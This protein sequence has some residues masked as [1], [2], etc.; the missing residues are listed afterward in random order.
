MKRNGC[1]LLLNIYLILSADIAFGNG[2]RTL[3]QIFRE[4]ST[5]KKENDELITKNKELQDKIEKEAKHTP[6]PTDRSPLA[7][8]SHEL[9]ALKSENENLAKQI[10]DLE[11]KCIQIAAW[12]EHERK[13]K[14]AK[15]K[16]KDLK[17]CLQEEP[18]AGLAVADW[19]N[20]INIGTPID[21]QVEYIRP[22]DECFVF[23]SFDNLSA[24]VEPY[25]F[26]SN[27]RSSLGSHQN[28]KLILGTVGV[29][30]CASYAMTDELSLNGMAGYFHSTLKWYE[31]KSHINGIYFGPGA[32]YRFED[33]IVAS[34]LF[35]IKNVHKSWDLDFRVE[36][37]FD[38][39]IPD[40]WV[41]HPLIRMDYLKVW[42]N[43]VS[44]SFLY[45]KL[46]TGAERKILCREE[47]YITANF[48]LSWIHMAPLTASSLKCEKADQSISLK[49]DSKNQ[50]GVG[51]EIIAMNV[52]GMLTAVQYEGAFGSSAPMQTGRI[53][54][55]WCW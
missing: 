33:G 22:H 23:H 4:N 12:Q 41:L 52:S 46:G 17:D 10:A 45:S 53:R 42:G 32:S 11:G 50:M 30:G 44:S 19:L 35:W 47:N 36:S 6:T 3:D 20:S 13:R 27:Y 28:M 26:Y 37:R 21:K 31:E 39:K 14:A 16:R 29:S 49:T 1:L 38:V 55:E 54:F 18:R 24:W 48:D 9:S 25:G 34:S 40:E 51:L 43:E 2:E 15:E 7:D 5:L 8:N